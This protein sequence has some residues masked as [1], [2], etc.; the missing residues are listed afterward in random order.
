MTGKRVKAALPVSGHNFSENGDPEEVG[1]A[2]GARVTKEEVEDV[3]AVSDDSDLEFSDRDSEDS[4]ESSGVDLENGG[5]P[6]LYSSNFASKGS[7][8]PC[9]HTCILQSQVSYA[10]LCFILLRLI[11][12]PLIG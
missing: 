8:L 1:I 12:F 11:L 7:F 9:E 4:D 2:S 5:G 3:F 10:S 6:L